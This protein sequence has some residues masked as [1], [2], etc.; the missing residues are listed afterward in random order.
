MRTLK[1]CFIIYFLNWAC[2]CSSIKDFTGTYRSYAYSKSAIFFNVQ[3]DFKKDSSFDYRM[4]YDLLGDN[5][6]GHYNFVGNYIYLYYDEDKMDTSFYSSV[7]YPYSRIKYLCY[8]SKKLFECDS[9]GKILKYYDGHWNKGKFLRTGK[10]TYY[11]KKGS[12]FD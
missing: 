10:A 1:S 7:K 8:K 11:F 4:A 9:T 12:L 3:I 5:A 6:T 2:S